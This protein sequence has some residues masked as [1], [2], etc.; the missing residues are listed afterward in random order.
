MEKKKIILFILL[1]LFSFS[2]IACGEKEPIN[3]DENENNNPSE[4]V[5]TDYYNEENFIE[6][7]N[8]VVTENK[9]VAYEGP[10]YLG[11]SDMV[12]VKANFQNL[13]VYETRVNHER[14]FSWMLPNEMAPVVIFDFEGTVHME[15]KFKDVTVTEAV[16]KPLVYGVSTTI[17]DNVIYFDLEYNGNYVLEYNGNS[18]NVLHIFANPIEEDPIYEEMAKNDDNIVY[19]GPGVYKADAIPVKDNEIIYLAG[20]AYV[21]GQIRAEGINNLTIRGRGIISGAIYNR[22]SESEYTIPIEM[23]SCDGVKIEGITF[24]DPAGWTVALYKSK[25]IEIDNIKIITARQ[26]GDGISVQSCENVN[27]TGGFVR[28]WDDSLVVKNVDNGSTKNVTFDSV[29][30]W[31]DLAQSMEIGYE[32]H[33]ET[34][35]DITFKNI[36]VIHNYHKAVISMHDADDAHISNVKYQNITVEDCETLGD[37]RNDGENDFLIDICILYNPDWSVSTDLKGTITNVEIENVKVYKIADTVISRIN[38]YSPTSN[39]T[40]IKIKGIEI[41]GKKI[42]SDKDLKLVCNDYSSDISVSSGEKVLGAYINL[43]YKLSLSGDTINNHTQFN[44][45]QVGMLVPDFARSKGDLPYIGVADS[46]EYTAQATHSAGTKTTTPADDGSGDFTKAGSS[47]ANAIDKDQ[48]TSWI[49]GEWKNEEDEF[50]ALTIDFGGEL[51]NVGVIRILGNPNNEFYYTY[52]FQVWGLK[53]KSDGTLNDKYTRLV[54]L[55]D[56]EMTP[57]ANNC[58]DVN[59][60]TQ[61]YAGIQIRFYKED[62]ASTPDYYE[63]SEVQFFA[64]SLSYNKAIVDSTPHNDVY[65][66]EKIVDGDATGTSYYE[67]S[68]LPAYIVIDLGDVYNVNTFVMC[69][70]PSLKWDARSEEIEIYVSSSKDS[71]SQ[72]LTEFT[73][74]VDKTS[75]LFDPQTGNR[76]IVNLENSV[77]ARY[78]KVIIYSNNIK[79]GYNAQL[80]EFSVYG[81]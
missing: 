23:R 29:V 72:N 66:V 77:E 81:E 24:L 37:N 42:S 47:A 75:Y 16:V 10:S 60:T 50:A 6:S 15:V 13:F 61:Q 36:T 40:N 12:E 65:N 3:D 45:E 56:Y 43:P 76:N 46:K 27:V 54:G 52:S 51:I 11:S 21:Y 74:V 63:V 19:I 9:L 14:Q 69:L 58:I 64:P 55:K 18:D 70:P 20:G 8:K 5:K 80:S 26:N 49:S 44:I 25:N 4:N 67:S 59:I 32:A 71:Y 57:G 17:V 53:L 38:G 34:M 68:E 31:T 48:S 62:Y 30:V 2:I 1:V 41:A 7:S 39:I 73:K 35:E 78:I 22:R 33:G 79:A 28:T